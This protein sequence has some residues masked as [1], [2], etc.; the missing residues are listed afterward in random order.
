MNIGKNITDLVNSLP[1]GVRL[2]AVSKTKPN[3]DI[4]EAYNAGQRIFGENKVQDLTKKYEEDVN[5]AA[6]SRE[7]DVLEDA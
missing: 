3:E 5:K 2:V 7:S 4:M 6:R 1:P